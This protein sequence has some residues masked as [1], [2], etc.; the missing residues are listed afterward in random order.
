[1]AQSWPRLS[2]ELVVFFLGNV[3]WMLATAGLLFQ[4]A[5]AHLCVS[6]LAEGQVLAGSG[7]IAWPL[8]LGAF[9][10]NHA[11]KLKKHCVLPASR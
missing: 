7:L 3:A 4:E 10:L 6:Y 11:L 2:A 1:M 5:E 8:L 9:A